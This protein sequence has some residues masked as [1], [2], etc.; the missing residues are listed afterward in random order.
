MP[1]GKS[2]GTKEE[3]SQYKAKHHAIIVYPKQ[4]YVDAKKREIGRCQ[5]PDCGRRVVAGNEQSFHFDHRVESTKC[6]ASKGDLLFGERGGVGGL[7]GNHSKAAALDKV[8][9]L[10]DAEM[11]PKCDLLCVNCHLCRKPRGLGRREV[12]E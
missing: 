5:Y 10:L 8:E 6:K 2:T 11:E 4:Q 12:A 1:D 7:V 9:H 3:V